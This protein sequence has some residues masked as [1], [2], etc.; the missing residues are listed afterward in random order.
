MRLQQVFNNNRG[1][2]VVELHFIWKV[3]VLVTWWITFVPNSVVQR[4]LNWS[5]Y[6]QCWLTFSEKPTGFPTGVKNMGGGLFK[7]WWQKGGG[8]AW[9]N[10]WREHGELKTLLKNTCERVHLLVKLLAI[11][12][13]A[14]KF[15]KNEIFYTY[16]SS[17]LD[18]KLLIIVRAINYC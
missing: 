13:Q 16:F 2:W 5:S 9:V 3:V 12:L 14:C 8:G 10:I 4:V 18:F 11:S 15:T 7:I 17:I 6:L 1:E